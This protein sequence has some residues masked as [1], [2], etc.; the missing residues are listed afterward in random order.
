MAFFDEA[1]FFKLQS[2]MSGGGRLWIVRDHDDGL[3]M[4]G[5]ETVEEVENRIGGFPVKVSGRFIGDEKVGVMNDGT[6]DGD[7]LFL[8]A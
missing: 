7:A 8:S 3:A 2:A 5:R 6:G 4:I 1:A